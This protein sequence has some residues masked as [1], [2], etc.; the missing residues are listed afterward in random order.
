M[1]LKR[2]E[3]RLADLDSQ[4]LAQLDGLLKRKVL[5]EQEFAKANEAARTQKADLEARRDELSRLLSRARVSEALIQRV[6]KAIK[7]FVEALQNLELRQQKAQLQTIL[8]AANIYKEGR[9]E[10][11]FRASIIQCVTLI[12]Q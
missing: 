6:P 2:V 12:N 8:K 4:F 10:L 9:I 3:K 1:E 11:E 7:T 5:T